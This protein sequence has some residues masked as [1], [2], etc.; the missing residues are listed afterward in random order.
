MHPPRLGT[1]GL[2]IQMS[3]H[4]NRNAV[5]TVVY[6][7]D[8]GGRLTRHVVA[9]MTQA[10]HQAAYNVGDQTDVERLLGWPEQLV[11]WHGHV[12]YATTV[13]FLAAEVRA[14]GGG[15]SGW[16][17]VR[18]E[19]SKRAGYVDHPTDAGATLTMHQ[20]QA[21]ADAFARD[22]ARHGPLHDAIT[23]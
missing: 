22:F 17:V 18:R 14:P 1:Q 19:G 23:G 13:T 2:E 4:P 6:M 7:R 11:R 10:E 16:T 20:A 3:N 8:A 15:T 12:G 5:K 21:T 9:G